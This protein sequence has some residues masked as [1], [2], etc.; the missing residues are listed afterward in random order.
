M[1]FGARNLQCG[2]VPAMFDDSKRGYYIIRH[3]ITCCLVRIDPS[4]IM[5]MAQENSKIPQFVIVVTIK[6]YSSIVGDP[7]KTMQNT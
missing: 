4:A 3:C 2:D 1:I 5:E 6:I 7:L